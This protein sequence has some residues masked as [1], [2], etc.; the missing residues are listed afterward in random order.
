MHFNC[1]VWRQQ[2]LCVFL[3]DISIHKKIVRGVYIKGWLGVVEG[4]FFLII[5][6]TK[7]LLILV[8]KVSVQA[9]LNLLYLLNTRRNMNE[10]CWESHEYFE[11][12]SKLLANASR[13]VF[14]AFEILKSKNLF[15]SFTWNFHFILLL[16]CI[17]KLSN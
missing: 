1:R 4:Y 3:F 12:F 9:P 10:S 6:V 13:C 8:K 7:V 15:G 16:Y 2:M 11:E 5:G 17:K 14:L